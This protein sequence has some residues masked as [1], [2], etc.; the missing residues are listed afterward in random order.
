[1]SMEKSWCSHSCVVSCVPYTSKA[2]INTK[3]YNVDK[4][5]A[6]TF[7]VFMYN[8][9]RLYRNSSSVYSVYTTEW[10]YRYSSSVYTTD[11]PSKNE[12]KKK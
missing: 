8:F 10:P 4:N 6:I 9:S 1:M 7:H 3:I 12:K 2:T 5:I 11:S